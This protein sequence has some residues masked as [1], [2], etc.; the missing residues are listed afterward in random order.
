MFQWLVL[1]GLPLVC[2]ADDDEFF[3]PLSY[4]AAPAAEQSTRPEPLPPL[5]VE[6]KL[7]DYKDADK[8]PEEL[9]GKAGAA[10]S[11]A[12]RIPSSIRQPGSENSGFD[13]LPLV[14]VKP[15]EIQVNLPALV[16]ENRPGWACAA[17]VEA[18][19]LVPQFRDFRDPNPGIAGRDLLD[20]D[21]FDAAPRVWLGFENDCGNGIRAR[22][23][24]IQ[25]SD[26]FGKILDPGV[27]TFTT[28]TAD[29]EFELYTID[30][31]Y[32]RRF[33]LPDCW[34]C[35]GGIGPR[36][37]SINRHE[38]FSEFAEGQYA[39]FTSANMDYQ[40]TGLTFS[41][42][43]RRPIGDWGLAAVL[44]GRGSILW[45]RSRQQG[46]SFLET[47]TSAG[48][49]LVIADEPSTA[50]ILELQAGLEWTKD[51]ACFKGTVFARC[52]FE[53]QNWNVN[54]PTYSL[55]QNLNGT[56]LLLDSLSPDVQ[57]YG[58]TFAV[59]FSR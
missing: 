32:T 14:A 49:Q 33:A 22:F 11:Q 4:D 2:R 37:A 13:P 9:P 28:A 43:G 50:W 59:G 56:T 16:E 23:W 36:F 45:G 5:G 21:R 18:T 46:E 29:Q 6:T 53:Y 1:I 35:V 25:G 20:L 38:G 26:G 19:F 58:I 27:F 12:A 17:G 42:E 8:S 47:G 10:N 54:E 3:V 48:Y 51:I 44:N 15:P 57:L 30:L 31:E 55:L 52:L 34:C 39:A 7:C 41:L 40:G 24:D